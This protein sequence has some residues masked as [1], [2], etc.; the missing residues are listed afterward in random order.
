MHSSMDI[1]WSTG[2][3]LFS[4]AFHTASTF[5]S[6]SSA[7][8]WSAANIWTAAEEK[9]INISWLSEI[10][11]SLVKLCSVIR[12]RKMHESVSSCFPQRA[13]TVVYHSTN[14]PYALAF[15]SL[16]ILPLL[17]HFVVTSSSSPRSLLLVWQNIG[18]EWLSLSAFPVLKLKLWTEALLWLSL[19][20]FKR[21]LPHMLIS[22]FPF[23][24]IYLQLPSPESAQRKLS[25]QN[26]AHFL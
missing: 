25:H 20:E 22:F 3:Q 7:R 13:K 16:R 10:L 17:L 26:H 8:L 15:K 9:T 14:I 24:P 21:S 19:I 2:D 12:L 1:A 5:H 6:T 18:G 4:K 23:L 11:I